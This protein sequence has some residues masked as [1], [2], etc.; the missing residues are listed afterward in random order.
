MYLE[1]SRCMAQM[2]HVY[3]LQHKPLNAFVAALSQLN[4][5]EEAQEDIHEVL[6]LYMYMYMSLLFNLMYFFFSFW[7]HMLLLLNAVKNSISR[8]WET[9]TLRNLSLCKSFN[10]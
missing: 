3:H 7:H 5:A 2:V 6:E 10:S 4:T 9:F 1:K 8:G